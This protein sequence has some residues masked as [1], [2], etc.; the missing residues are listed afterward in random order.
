MKIWLLCL[1]T[2]GS[3]KY[4]NAPIKLHLAKFYYCYYLI[5]KPMFQLKK[6]PNHCQNKIWNYCKSFSLYLSA[7][8]IYHCFN[9]HII[10][11]N[12]TYCE[13][14]IRLVNKFTANACTCK[15]FFFRWMDCTY[16][17]LNVYIME[18]RIFSI[19]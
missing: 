14:L 15:N 7:D 5:N 12:M 9:G 8:T 19:K 10:N 16:W 11:D 1:G 6:P 4:F 2:H 17:Y 18:L 13:N 3:Q